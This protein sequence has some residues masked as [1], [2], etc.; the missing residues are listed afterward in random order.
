M[1]TECRICGRR[2]SDQDEFFRHFYAVHKTAKINRSSALPLNQFRENLKSQ[3]GIAESDFE[4]SFDYHYENESRSTETRGGEIFITPSYC[5][6]IA[7]SVKTKYPR[8]SWLDKENG[9]PVVYHG[10]SADNAG[11][12]IRKGLLMNGGNSS[13]SH[14][15]VHGPGVYVSPNPEV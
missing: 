4:P 12:I 11:S 9:W 14:G 10:T 13:P 2:Y 15:A 3:Y 8:D 6:K 7:L 5:T 1:S